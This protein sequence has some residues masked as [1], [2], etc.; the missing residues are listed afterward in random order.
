M[1]TFHVITL[2]CKLNIYESESI[3]FNLQSGDF[4]LTNS[5]VADIIIIN[6]CTVTSKADSKCRNMIRKTRRNNP[7]SLVI[8]CGCLVNT[9][10]ENI[11]SMN[12]V[13]VFVENENKDKI[14]TIIK[15]YEKKSTPYVFT[16]END[17]TFNYNTSKMSNH[18][19]AFVKIQDGCDNRCSYCKIP[20]ARG[21]GRS[22]KIQDVY[23]EIGELRNSGYKE[24]ILTGVNIG[25][26]NNAGIDF[27]GLLGS[28]SERYGD[29]RLRISSIELQYI[30]DEFLKVFSKDNICSHIHIPLQSGSDK[31]LKLMNRNYD[32]GVYLDKI[33]KIRVAKHDPFISTDIIFGFPGESEKDFEKTLDLI[34]SVE[35]AYIH[36]FG[37][38]PRHGTEA[39][40][41]LPK[42]PERIRDER[43]A[44]VKKI[45]DESNRKYVEKYINKELEVI[46]E[47]KKSDHYMGK[48]DNYLDICIKSN[49]ILEPKKIYK[50]LFTGIEKNINWGR[51]V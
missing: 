13:D 34:K 15:T 50:V 18:S 40:D 2:G 29:I 11:L 3:I 31:I 10:K 5:P 1:K 24:F 19:R 35:F 30:N 48:S 47:N 28:L 27:N 22:R 36:I 32:T 41:L 21:K 14:N 4:I 37:F 45:S 23:D 33:K 51:V 42:I 26:Y 49:E 46:I 16:D 8:V 6:T 38:S 9:D 25:S 44:V 12:E 20:L 17:G 39:Y 7:D 43:I